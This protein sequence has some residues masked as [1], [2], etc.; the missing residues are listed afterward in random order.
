MPDDVERADK[1]AQYLRIAARLREEITAR[2]WKLGEEIPGEIA[3]AERFGVSR[4]TIVRALEQLRAEGLIVTL[5]G[6]GSRVASLP[7]VITVDIGPD[8]EVGARLPEDSE[9]ERLGM[10]PG[11]PV[12]L[13]WR[14]GTG[15]PELYDAAI[16][17]IR[18][19]PPG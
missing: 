5:S 11:V 15:Q 16:T 2:E 4:G 10:P 18:A 17:R 1:R 13:V 12:L 7:V 6:R 19:A 8:D 14:H 9:R 3:L